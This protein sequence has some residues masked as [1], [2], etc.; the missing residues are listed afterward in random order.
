[1]L[2][3]QNQNDITHFYKDIGIYKIKMVI[4]QILFVLYKCH[5]FVCPSKIYLDLQRH[6]QKSHKYFYNLVLN[7]VKRTSYIGKST[8]LEI[9]STNCK[10]IKRCLYIYY[11]LIINQSNDDIGN[12]KLIKYFAGDFLN[13]ASTFMFISFSILMSK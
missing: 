6:S 1:M 11:F 5:N 8:L 10:I 13:F 3:R 12:Q 2:V 9:I 4:F 7:S